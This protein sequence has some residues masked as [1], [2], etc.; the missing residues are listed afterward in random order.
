MIYAHILSQRIQFYGKLAS[1]HPYN[2]QWI[3]GWLRREVCTF[4]L[5]ARAVGLDSTDLSGGSP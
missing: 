4:P 1:E 3:N 5:P 2:C